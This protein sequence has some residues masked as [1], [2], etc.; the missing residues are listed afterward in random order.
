MQRDPS[1]AVAREISADAPSV[2]PVTMT[3][4]VQP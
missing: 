3:T 2:F 4:R 1:S